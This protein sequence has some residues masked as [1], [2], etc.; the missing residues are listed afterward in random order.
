MS[1]AS[2]IAIATKG[3]RGG[4]GID[5]SGATI[6]AAADI[7]VEVVTENEATV[8]TVEAV[9]IVDDEIVVTVESENEAEVECP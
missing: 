8:E 3:F 9:A 1:V 6:V 7:K 5:L 4:G 2:R